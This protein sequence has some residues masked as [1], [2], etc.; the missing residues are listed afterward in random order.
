M[1]VLFVVVLVKLFAFAVIRFA[2]PT[3][4]G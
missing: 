4:A 1:G 2:A 3:A